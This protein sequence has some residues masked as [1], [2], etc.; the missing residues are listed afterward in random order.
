MA[1][2]E[3]FEDMLSDVSKN[4]CRQFWENKKQWNLAQTLNIMRKDDVMCDVTLLVGSEKMPF[5]AHRLVLAAAF[6]YF[7]AI[8]SAE[9]KDSVMNELDLQCISS[10]DMALLLEF[11][12]K[13][14]TDIH[15]ENAH[16][17]TILAK[18]FGAECL[19]DQC[20]RFMSQFKRDRGTKKMVKFADC[21]E[22]HKLMFN[23]ITTSFTEEKILYAELD[24]LPVKSVLEVIRHPAAVICDNDP[25]QNEEM[26][27]QMMMARFSSED[28]KGDHIL[29]LLESIHLPQVSAAFLDTAETQ[30]R[31]IPAVKNLIKE[32][33]KEI[34]PAETREWYL[35]RYKNKASVQIE[36]HEENIYVR[37][38]VSHLY[39]PRVL[40]Q[41]FPFFLYVYDYEY[42]DE[43]LEGDAY[44]DIY[45]PVNIAL[46][47]PAPIEKV[48][49]P[50]PL[51]VCSQLES[52]KRYIIENKYYAGKVEP[53]PAVYCD[54]DCLGDNKFCL[55]VE[56][57]KKH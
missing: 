39:S 22:I 7:K 19:L 42:E 53:G 55:T 36:D 50:Y 54:P 47:C 11:A 52:G 13:G 43:E 17:V 37:G 10:E 32:A 48:I 25:M 24:K 28:E 18:Y 23:L 8:F 21:F 27:F 2:A 30:F 6:D 14:E 41:G 3:E 35:P 44:H 4:N 29:K 49:L 46:E 20:C 26:L 38:E 15:Q 56:R 40:V 31:H 12:Y 57:C 1:G 16:K 33:R 34:D 51:K 5:R 45:D 9:M